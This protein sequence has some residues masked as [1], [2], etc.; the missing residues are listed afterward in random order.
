MISI[1]AIP[2][3]QPTT[4]PAIVLPETVSVELLELVGVGV[5]VV[6]VVVV[7]AGKL[8]KELGGD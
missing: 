7:D 2:T 5:V 4:A 3:T 8:E 1:A 6:V